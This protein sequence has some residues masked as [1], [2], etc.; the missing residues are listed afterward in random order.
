MLY[1]SVESRKRI[2]V[3]GLLVL[4]IFL[5]LSKFEEGQDGGGE[6]KGR[7]VFVDFILSTEI[8]HFRGVR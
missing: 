7:R 5:T 1:E 6:C 3:R 2:S 4:P 8:Y